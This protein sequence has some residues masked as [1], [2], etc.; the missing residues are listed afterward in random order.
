MNDDLKDL[1]SDIAD[2]L[3]DHADA[4]VVGDPPHYRPNRAMSLLARVNAVL[5]PMQ[6][7]TLSGCP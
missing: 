7:E 5:E 6:P 3:D 4:E 2:Y 1:L